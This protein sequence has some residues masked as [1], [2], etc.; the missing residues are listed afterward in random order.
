MSGLRTKGE[1][2]GQDEKACGARYLLRARE[3]CRERTSSHSPAGSHHRG[4]DFGCLG[5]KPPDG[6]EWSED[7]E[8]STSPW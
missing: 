1:G 3:G 6:G 4:S 7:D 5:L 2:L 8:P